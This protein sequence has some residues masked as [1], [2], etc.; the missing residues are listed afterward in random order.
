MPA[1]RIVI[2]SLRVIVYSFLP[3]RQYFFDVSMDQ[4]YF[5]HMKL[6]WDLAARAKNQVKSKM[7]YNINFFVLPLFWPLC[8]LAV[9]SVA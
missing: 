2:G 5:S 6:E 4:W 9:R 1:S 3:V 7:K 8:A